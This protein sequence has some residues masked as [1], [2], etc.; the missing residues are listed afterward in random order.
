RA[1]PRRT[2][3]GL[4][5]RSG[6][7]R[8]A[9]Q[10]RRR[11]LPWMLTTALAIGIPLDAWAQFNPRVAIK[12]PGGVRG[13]QP[14][15]ALV[16]SASGGD[17][18]VGMGWSLSGLSDIARIN[19]GSGINFNSGDTFAHSGSGVLV[20]QTGGTYRSKKE[21][22]VKFTPSGTCGSGPCSWVATDRS[23]M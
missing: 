14:S 3:V 21:S 8:S 2:R 12:I 6:F 7:E 18:I 4:L 17:G 16:Y 13:M 5:P 20:W 11:H 10:V 23:G 9:M 1:T 22:F 19:Y 15:L